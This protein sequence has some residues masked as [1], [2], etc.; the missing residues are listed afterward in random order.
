ML[1]SPRLIAQLILT[2]ICVAIYDMFNSAVVNPVHLHKLHNSKIFFNYYE[3]DTALCM[4]KQNINK[5][6]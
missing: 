2:N 4:N 6:R 3:N 1:D 5:K